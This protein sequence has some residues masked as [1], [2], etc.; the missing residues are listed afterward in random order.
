MT[1]NHK[2]KLAKAPTLEEFKAN[3]FVKRLAYGFSDTIDVWR[4]MD[5]TASFTKNKSEMNDLKNK[6]GIFY[7]AMPVRQ[8]II[9]CQKELL[10]AGYKGNALL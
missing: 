6:L 10:D 3:G 4:R 9:Q 5:A 2:T 7:R 1:L 8:A